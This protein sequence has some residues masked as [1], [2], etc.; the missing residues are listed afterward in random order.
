MQSAQTAF[1]KSYAVLMAGAAEREH[2]TTEETLDVGGALPLDPANTPDG[3][4][5]VCEACHGTKSGEAYTC[6][7]PGSRREP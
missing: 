4:N 3:S 5:D 6:S 7:R 2:R 1:C